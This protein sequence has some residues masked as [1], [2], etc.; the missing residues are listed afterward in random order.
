MCGGFYQN[1]TPV[2]K[3]KAACEVEEVKKSSI[4]A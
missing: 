1:D 2:K 3:K 4:L